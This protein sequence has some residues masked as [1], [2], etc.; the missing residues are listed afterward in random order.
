MKLTDQKYTFF[1]LDESSFNLFLS[2]NRGWGKPGEAIKLICPNS[3]GQNISLIA[4]IGK[5]GLAY[6]DLFDG[7]IDK[8]KYL[9]HRY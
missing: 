4:V 9:K 7:S 1:Y 5:E 3:K 2:R 8:V 6:W